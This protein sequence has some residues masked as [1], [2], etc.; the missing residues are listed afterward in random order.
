MLDLDF[1]IVSASSQ[2]IVSDWLPG[3]LASAIAVHKS[4][5]ELSWEPVLAG[6]R[7]RTRAALP[8]SFIYRGVAFKEKDERE[9]EKA[10]TNLDGESAHNR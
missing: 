6:R 7:H 2:D 3:T 9:W 1:I 10:D 5:C 4:N 8:E